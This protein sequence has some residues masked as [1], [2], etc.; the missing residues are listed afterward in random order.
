MEPKERC[1]LWVQKC[2]PFP[3]PASPTQCGRP[4]TE[5]RNWGPLSPSALKG[6]LLWA[7]FYPRGGF[8]SV[9][10]VSPPGPALKLRLAS[11]PHTAVTSQTSTQN[12]PVLAGILLHLFAL[13]LPNCH[14]NPA[15]QAQS[16]FCATSSSPGTTAVTH[17]AAAESMGTQARLLQDGLS[18]SSA[19]LAAGLRLEGAGST[20]CGLGITGCLPVEPKFAGRICSMG[21]QGSKGHRDSLFQ[22]PC[23]IQESLLMCTGHELYCHRHPE[24]FHITTLDFP[25]L[26]SA[27]IAFPACPA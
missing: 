12:P 5:S 17:R 19:L 3:L 13:P 27:A 7:P 22:T 26:E 9:L 6:S 18:P 25:E 21:Y 16:A 23:S 4:R 24:H 2:L 14:S 15:E 1:C 10:S 8:S 11:A 20:Q